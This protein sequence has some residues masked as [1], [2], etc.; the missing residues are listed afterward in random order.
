MQTKLTANRRSVQGNHRTEVARR[1]E[2]PQRRQEGRGRVQ[3]PVDG[4]HRAE[5]PLFRR[6]ARVQ[7]VS[8]TS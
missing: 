5:R 2:L 6:L 1:Q 4:P 3:G 8:V 7:R